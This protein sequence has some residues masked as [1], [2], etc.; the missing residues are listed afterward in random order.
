MLHV[1]ATCSYIH[2]LFLMVK[3]WAF[4]V[5][6]SKFTSSGSGMGQVW[7]SA[8]EG[9]KIIGTVCVKSIEKSTYVER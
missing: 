7:C 4:S 8:Q 9:S 1:Y 2:A 5:S 3:F 6:G